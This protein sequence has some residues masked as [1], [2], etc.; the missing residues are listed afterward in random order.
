MGKYALVAAVAA[1]AVAAAAP[2]AL[3]QTTAPLDATYTAKAQG[4]GPHSRCPD[5]AFAC[6]T[7][8]DV[9]FGSFAYEFDFTDQGIMSTLKFPNSTLVLDETFQAITMP[10]Q[11]GSSN[12]P[13]HALGHP[14]TAELTW[15]VDPTS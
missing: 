11:S 1:V 5:G 2:V 10:G 4:P 13:D 7:G 14:G 12:Q 15:T 6:G 8:T 9:S 3:A